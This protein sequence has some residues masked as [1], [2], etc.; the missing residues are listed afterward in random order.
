LKYGQSVNIIKTESEDK[1]LFVTLEESFGEKISFAC[2]AVP[3]LKEVRVSRLS[4]LDKFQIRGLTMKNLK[5]QTALFTASDEILPGNAFYFAASE[6]WKGALEKDLF[7]IDPLSEK[8]I[9]VTIYKAGQILKL[10]SESVFFPTWTQPLILT[11]EDGQTVFTAHLLGKSDDILVKL[12]TKVEWK[13]VQL[14][15]EAYRQELVYSVQGIARNWLKKE[16]G[17]QPPLFFQISDKFL[18]KWR[19]K[20]LKITRREGGVRIT[21]VIDKISLPEALV[22]ALAETLLKQNLLVVKD[23]WYSAAGLSGLSPMGK[24][25]KERIAREPM[26]SIGILY[27]RSQGEKDVLEKL[28]RSGLIY[29]VES[30]FI[31]AENFENCQ[32]WFENLESKDNLLAQIQKEFELSRTKAFPLMQR[33]REG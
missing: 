7:C 16:I 33:L 26:L 1:K 17:D 20:I 14:S 4:T 30:W 22:R 3:S 2:Y 15:E 31:T 10:Y 18:N 23:G 19:D 9:P 32:K 24:S 25:I 28:I 6:K 8:Q 5:L 29:R 21:D 27:F 13:R 11:D 12:W